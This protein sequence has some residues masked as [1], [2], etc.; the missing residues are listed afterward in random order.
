MELEEEFDVRIVFERI[1]GIE[2]VVPD[3]LS[4]EKTVKAL[5]Q[6]KQEWHISPAR[7]TLGARWES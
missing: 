5:E 6:L 4:R 2:E 3:F 7:M 1:A